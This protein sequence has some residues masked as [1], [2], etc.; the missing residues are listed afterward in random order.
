MITAMETDENATAMIKN[1][2]S[3]LRMMRTEK[4]IVLQQFREL[5]VQRGTSK[6]KDQELRSN[7][8][9]LKL[10]LCRSNDAK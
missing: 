1:T 10:E 8:E 4:N 6:H 2:L 9:E 5:K 3:T 7:C